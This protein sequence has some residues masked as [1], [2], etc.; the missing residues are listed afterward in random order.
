MTLMQ[1]KDVILRLEQNLLKSLKPKSIDKIL[2]LEKT[3]TELCCSLI[4]KYFQ[5]RDICISEESRFTL[6]DL[7]KALALVP[8]YHKMVYFFLSVLIKNEILYKDGDHYVF[9]SFNVTPSDQILRKIAGLYPKFHPFFSFVEHCSNNY[10]KVLSGASL[11]VNIIFPEGDS[12]QLERIYQATPQ[13][14]HEQLYLNLLKETL[15]VLMKDKSKCRVIEVGGGQGILTDV[16]IPAIRVSIEKY[17]FTDIGQAFIQQGQRK[18]SYLPKELMEFAVY[19]V[20]ADPG[21]QGLE[22]E[23]YDCVVGFNVLHATKDVGESLT[24]ALRLLKENGCILLV[25]NIKQQI[26]IDMIYGLV[27]GWWSFDDGI[28]EVSPLLTHQQWNTLL[29]QKGFN[30]FSVFPEANNELALIDTSLIIIQK[31]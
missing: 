7:Y 17:H 11:G 12:S 23:S 2:G 3:A 31:T 27:D 5:E 16:L 18:Y 30:S 14:G 19:D 22:I 24:H 15:L 6:T 20:S 4:L 13:I 9:T 29:Q 28:R 10:S 1:K 8:K 21:Q 26:W 25:E